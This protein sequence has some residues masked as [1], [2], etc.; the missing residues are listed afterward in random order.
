MSASSTA[1][2]CFPGGRNFRCGSFTLIRSPVLSGGSTI[3]KRPLTPDR[4]LYV[5]QQPLGRIA[6]M[7]ATSQQRPFDNSP[8]SGRSRLE[9]IFLA[10]SVETC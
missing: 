6:S 1:N 2:D 9:L 7:P 10:G 8:G 4:L 5:V 3:H